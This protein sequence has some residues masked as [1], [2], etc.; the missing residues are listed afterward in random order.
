MRKTNDLVTVILSAVVG[1]AGFVGL[2]FGFI[3]F[4]IEKRIT[5]NEEEDKRRLDNRIKRRAIDDE[6]KHSVGRLLFWIVRAIQ[7]GE[8]NG[9]LKSAY[10]HFEQS[11]AKQKDLDRE[12]LATN[13]SE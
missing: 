8:H 13:E 7:T 10:E 9:E 5:K 12:I 1:G 4:Y 2:L 6:W 11:E 3:R